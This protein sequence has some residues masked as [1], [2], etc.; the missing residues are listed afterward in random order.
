[1]PARDIIV[2]GASA[3]GVHALSELVSGLPG[4]LP[5]AVFTVLHLGGGRSALPEI[6]NRAGKL[7]AM[8]PTDGEAIL[9]GRIYAAPPDRHL[10][11]ADG[12]VQVARGP[13]ENGHRPAID[14]LFRSAARWH[15]RRVIGVVLTGNLDDGTAGL[16]A[17]KKL[18]GVAVVQDPEDAD[19]P[20]MPA[21]ALASVPVDHVLPLAE[22]PE[23][24]VRLVHEP[25]EEDAVKAD[26]QQDDVTEDL[27]GKPGEEM[28]GAP[29]GFTCPDC[30]G[31]LWEAIE[32][33]LVR[34]RCRTGHAFSPESLVASQTHALEAALWAAVRSLEESRSLSARMAERMHEKG[35]S[36]VERRYR[37]RAQEAERHSAALRRMLDT[38][39]ETDA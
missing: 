5:A 20:S 11:I 29:S 7:P 26:P 15:G 36:T 10:L 6:L 4:D 35:L 2:I 27:L 13:R 25:V 22:L 34:Y 31:A 30:G 16:L 37:R 23:M 1:M 3:G 12:T 28:N 38:A 24:L 9:P 14:V 33:D 32:G 21:S 19:Y 39:V 8:H 17:I 18:G